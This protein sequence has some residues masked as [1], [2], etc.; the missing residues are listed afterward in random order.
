MTDQEF[1][2]VSA[3]LD[4]F[5][6]QVAMRAEMMSFGQIEAKDYK[7]WAVQ[8]DWPPFD[9]QSVTCRLAGVSWWY[10]IR[11]EDGDDP[12]SYRWFLYQQVGQILHHFSGPSSPILEPRMLESIY[13]E[14]TK[15]SRA[16][17]RGK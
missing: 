5:D 12:E 10:V 17:Q 14:L 15:A 9:F 4:R 13:D 7:K 1:K 6:T 8:Q 3:W 16:H 11:V 2:D